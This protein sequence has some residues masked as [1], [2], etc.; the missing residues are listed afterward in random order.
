M[1]GIR[2]IFRNSS[3]VLFCCRIC[4][5][6][7]ENRSCAVHGLPDRIGLSVDAGSEAVLS[8]G[9][10]SQQ[11]LFTGSRA[12]TGTVARNVSWYCIWIYHCGCDFKKYYA[13][14]GKEYHMG[15]ESTVIKKRKN[16]MAVLR[17]DPDEFSGLTILRPYNIVRVKEK[18]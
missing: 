17:D 8:D 14:A 6:Y 11:E 16:K 5:Y 12:C 9:W 3:C 4:I 18:I 10:R 2:I 15:K 1:H 13:G 7:V